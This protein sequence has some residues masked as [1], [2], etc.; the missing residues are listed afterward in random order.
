MVY[1][2][3]LYQNVEKSNLEGILFLDIENTLFK[4]IKNRCFT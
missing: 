4:K 3:S 2:V 1:D